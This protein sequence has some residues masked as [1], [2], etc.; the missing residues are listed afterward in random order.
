M[1]ISVSTGKTRVIKG[2]PAALG[3]TSTSCGIRRCDD[4]HRAL[5]L[6]RP[7]QRERIGQPTEWIAKDLFRK[8]FQMPR[9][10][11]LGTAGWLRMAFRDSV[12]EGSNRT[13]QNT[14]STKPPVIYQKEK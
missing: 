10:V 5:G 1:K 3:K 12:T 7:P 2:D 14:N 6:T 8:A 9:D 11:L 13:N 4:H